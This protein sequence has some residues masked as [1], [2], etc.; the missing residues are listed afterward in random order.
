MD[1][2]V[3]TECG[4]GTRQLVVKGE[5]INCSRCKKDA[6]SGIG[7]KQPTNFAL[8]MGGMIQRSL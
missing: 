7:F 2:M 4:H 8:R 1:Y 3:Y 5:P 6:D